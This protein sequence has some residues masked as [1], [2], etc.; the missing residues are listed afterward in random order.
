MALLRRS[1]HLLGRLA[2]WDHL[3]TVGTPWATLLLLLLLLL[4]P[5]HLLTWLPSHL[6]LLTSSHHLL[7]LGVHRAV[8]WWLAWMRAWRSHAV[9]LRPAGHVAA[10]TSTHEMWRLRW[11]HLVAHEV[12]GVGRPA[13]LCAFG[14]WRAH[15][16]WV[17]LLWTTLHIGRV[18]RRPRSSA[19]WRSALEWRVG[20]GRG[21]R[22]S[23]AS[24]TTGTARPIPGHGHAVATILLLSR[25]HEP[26]LVL[27]LKKHQLHLIILKSVIASTSLLG[28]IGTAGAP[29]G[30]WRCSSHALGIVEGIDSSSVRSLSNHWRAL[31][32]RAVRIWHWLAH[33]LALLLLKVRGISLNCLLLHRWR[34]ILKGC[35]LFRVQR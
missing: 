7:L 5:L 31:S 25:H 12:H 20:S 23:G 24:G 32:R 6:A 10:A 34:L 15:A 1:L 19:L 27:L 21:T 22:T 33:L 14:E 2:L 29:D 13:R 3:S 8:E 35:E 17:H 26:L 9:H 18:R 16:G 4:L 30:T 28:G 11:V